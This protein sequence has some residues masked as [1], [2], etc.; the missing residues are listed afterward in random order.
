MIEQSSSPAKASFN[1]KTEVGLQK[2]TKKTEKGEVG[3][4]VRENFPAVPLRTQGLFP[5]LPLLPSVNPISAFGLKVGEERAPGVW[6]LARA[7]D[8]ER[9]AT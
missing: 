5:W 3:I 4:F 6:T 1:P 8:R 9:R 2:E 7:L